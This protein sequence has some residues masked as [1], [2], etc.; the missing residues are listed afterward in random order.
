LAGS[1]TENVTKL[2]FASEQ[3]RVAELSRLPRLLS[4][5]DSDRQRGVVMSIT[6]SISAIQSH[7]PPDVDTDEMS[8][9]RRSVHRRWYWSLWAPITLT[10]ESPMD[11]FLAS[12]WLEQ[13]SCRF[14]VTLL[15]FSRAD[16]S[17]SQVLTISHVVLS[18]LLLK[19]YFKKACIL[20]RV[21]TSTD[22][23][24]GRDVTR[25]SY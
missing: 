21:Q 19:A 12:H 14:S 24:H 9:N 6:V 16:H 23:F 7:T 11:L 3:M 17:T 4:S 18:P 10:V 13:S 20:I 5:D 1:T 22:W 8:N 25:R 2:S 15:V